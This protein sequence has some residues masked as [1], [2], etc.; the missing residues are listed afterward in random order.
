MKSGCIVEHAPKELLI[1]SM[2]WFGIFVMLWHLKIVPDSSICQMKTRKKLDPK[3]TSPSYIYRLL[4]IKVT[5]TL[6]GNQASSITG[7]D[8]II[9]ASSPESVKASLEVQSLTI[10]SLTD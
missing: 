6:S 8:I 10:K 1:R 9:A 4:K 7:N 2:N 3:S 5:E